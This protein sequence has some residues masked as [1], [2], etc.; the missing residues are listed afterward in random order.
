MLEIVP[1]D[2]KVAAGAAGSVVY[3]SVPSHRVYELPDPDLEV[4]APS[5]SSDRDGRTH[6]RANAD[7]LPQA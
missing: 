4:A 5:T 6:G 2:D 1:A 3:W 7:K